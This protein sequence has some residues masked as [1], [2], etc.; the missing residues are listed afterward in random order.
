METCLIPEREGRSVS[1]L[2]L[3]LHVLLISLFGF[4]TESGNYDRDLALDCHFS[5]TAR[6]Q[7]FTSKSADCLKVSMNSLRSSNSTKLMQSFDC[8]IANRIAA[9]AFRPAEERWFVSA[10]E[11]VRQDSAQL[12]IPL[13]PA[14]MPGGPMR[15]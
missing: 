2:D 8:N 15:P 5:C 3:A 7:S 9:A 1:K 6:I 14:L 4:V 10:H 13:T 12:S 11:S